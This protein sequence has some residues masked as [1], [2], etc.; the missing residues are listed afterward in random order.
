MNMS[1]IT[2]TQFVSAIEEI[3]DHSVLLLEDI[4]RIKAFSDDNNGLS[5][6]TVLNTLDGM[7]SKHGLIVFMTTNSIDILESD[8]ALIRPGR[9]D[10]RM[11]LGYC[12]EYQAR[13]FV[14]SFG[15]T[16]DT[17][18]LIQEVLSKPTTP[19]ELQNKVMNLME[20]I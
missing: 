16:M 15:L 1:K 2:D 14:A 19:A 10:L 18:P 8:P 3:R 13:K 4:D 17:E 9:I 20:G 6:A 7:T 11:E 5:F 12:D